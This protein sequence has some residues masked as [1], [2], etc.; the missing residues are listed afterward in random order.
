ME[1]LP[2]ELCEKILYNAVSLDDFDR[3]LLRWKSISSFV[4]RLCIPRV[5]TATSL[6]RVCKYW[7]RITPPLPCESLIISTASQ[8]RLALARLEPRFDESAGRN[9]GHLVKRIV[10]AFSKCVS[11]DSTDFR[12]LLSYCPNLTALHITRCFQLEPGLLLNDIL[13]TASTL[14]VLNLEETFPISSQ[15]PP[16]TEIFNKMPALRAARQDLHFSTTSLAFPSNIE[17]LSIPDHPDCP[18]IPSTV[19]E[20]VCYSFSLP[21]HIDLSGTSLTRLTLICQLPRDDDFGDLFRSLIS[22]IPPSVKAL[23]LVLYSWDDL[24][25]IKAAIPKN[26]TFLGLDT[27][28][29]SDFV[30][31]HND[32]LRLVEFCESVEAPALDT[33][34][35]MWWDDCDHLRERCPDVLVRLVSTLRKR[36]AALMDWEGIFIS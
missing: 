36:N 20:L 18:P 3:K 5:R 4:E 21:L 16:W 35:L 19:T 11:V 10:I 13:Q 7:N 32:P 22:S 23:S 29:R 1:S 15:I 14:Q 28:L 17:F 26:V 30:G 6:L 2:L 24:S 27:Q 34:Q 12:R 33:V 9:L 31:V 25:L 8:L